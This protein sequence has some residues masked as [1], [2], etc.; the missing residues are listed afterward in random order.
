MVGVSIHRACAVGGRRGGTCVAGAHMLE[1][2][3]AH[4]LN[5]QRRHERMEKHRC[6]PV[7]GNVDK[8]KKSGLAHTPDA[9]TPKRIC[10]IYMCPFSETNEPNVVCLRACNEAVQ[11]NP[12][13]FW[14]E[15]VGG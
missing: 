12:I 5:D 11:D 3:H 4:G 2:T 7:R 14:S 1:C 10:K 13:N 9:N 8:H 6:A 15:G